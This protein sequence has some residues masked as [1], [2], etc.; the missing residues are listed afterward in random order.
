MTAIV[1]ATKNAS[2][3]V[4]AVQPNGSEAVTVRYEFDLSAALLITDVIKLG[5]LPANC[6]VTD[7]MVDSDDLS[8]SAAGTFGL[9]ILASTG[10]TV[11]TTAS[12]GAAWVAGATTMQAG[13]LL[14]AA[15]TAHTRM[16]VSRT[17]DQL[18]GIVMAASCTTVATG[19][20]GLTLTYIAA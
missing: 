12:G 18:I 3:A 11:D 15:S 17:A 9:G 19:K 10:L 13:G 8:D 4:P 2:R 20:I 16:V 6:K 1:Y 14:R 7:W 5:Y